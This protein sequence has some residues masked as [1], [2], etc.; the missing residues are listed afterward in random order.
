MV[1][2]EVV[3]PPRSSD[4]IGQ[5]LKESNKVEIVNIL[6]LLTLDMT[7]LVVSEIIF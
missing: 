2:C 4:S 6:A 7:T 3:K 1:A 5:M